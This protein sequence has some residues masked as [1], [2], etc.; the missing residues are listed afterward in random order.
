MIAFQSFRIYFT[1]KN[2]NSINKTIKQLLFVNLF[3]QMN[4]RFDDSILDLGDINAEQE[5]YFFNFFEFIVQMIKYL[6]RVVIKDVIARDEESFK[7]IT[8]DLKYI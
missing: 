6:N 2:A 8:K 7:Q 1:I 5:G 4:Y 3:D